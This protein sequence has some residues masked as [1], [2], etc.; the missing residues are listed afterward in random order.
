[1]AKGAIRSNTQGK[2]ETE[3]RARILADRTERLAA[4]PAPA[5]RFEL[6]ALIALPIEQSLYGA[7]CDAVT[8]VR[9]FKGCSPAPASTPAFLGLAADGGRIWQVLDLPGL[10]GHPPAGATGGWLLF[11]RNFDGLCLLCPER[12]DIVEAELLEDEDLGRAR[13][14]EDAPRLMS[15]VSFHDLLLPLLSRSNF[16]A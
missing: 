6:A 14:L 15:L 16:G 12:P 7:P 3:R 11:L 13:T 5:G 4:A 10:L 8:R 1:V 9:P 2:L